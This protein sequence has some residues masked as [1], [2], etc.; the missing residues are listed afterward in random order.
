M[1]N[2]ESPLKST[3]PKKFYTDP[4]KKIR[5]DFLEEE[6]RQANWEGFQFKVGEVILRG[7]AASINKK[8]E[9]EIQRLTERLAFVSPKL[10]EATRELKFLRVHELECEATKKKL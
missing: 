7:K 1:E 10:E 3:P 9:E 8:N 4:G 5:T 2:F 6:Q